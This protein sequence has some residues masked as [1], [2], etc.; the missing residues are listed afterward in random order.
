MNSTAPIV[1]KKLIDMMARNSLRICI[2]PL[3]SAIEER[4]YVPVDAGFLMFWRRGGNLSS[5][6]DSRASPSETTPN[7]LP[8]RPV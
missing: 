4:R 6:T 3:T 1:Q 2:V 7:A 8:I 5:L